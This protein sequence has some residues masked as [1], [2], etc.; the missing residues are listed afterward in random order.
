MRICASA[1]WM[2]RGEGAVDA[3]REFLQGAW[4]AYR[5]GA[6]AKMALEFSE[7]RRDRKD[8]RR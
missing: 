2:I 1:R 8:Q 3:Q 6:I 4:R 7:D 5:P